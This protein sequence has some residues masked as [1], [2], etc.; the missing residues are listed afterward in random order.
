MLR[1]PTSFPRTYPSLIQNNEQFCEFLASLDYTE[2]QTRYRRLLAN[3]ELKKEYQNDLSKIKL[4]LENKKFFAST[5]GE[6]ILHLMSISKTLSKMVLELIDDPKIKIISTIQN[7]VFDFI[8]II[9]GTKTSDPNEFE[10]PSHIKD[11][12]IDLLGKYKV[13]YV[14]ADKMNQLVQDTIENDSSIKTFRSDYNN[15]LK[16]LEN[17]IKGN[18]SKLLEM[19]N[20][21]ESIKIIKE[22][23][24]LYRTKNCNQNIEF[25][26]AST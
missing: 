19:K 21:M 7:Y 15:L 16:N 11:E 23:I 1:V 12:Y 25:K 22:S 10:V 20:N 17:Q 8:D 18:Q 3:Y 2:I 6:A 4:E 14:I 9:Y 26:M 5:N 13:L 24:D